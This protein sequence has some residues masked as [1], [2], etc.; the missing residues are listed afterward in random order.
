[1]YFFHGSAGDAV[2][3]LSDSIHL[4]TDISHQGDAIETAHRT[5]NVH[6]DQGVHGADCHQVGGTD[7]HV[8]I[9]RVFQCH[10]SRC[11]LTEISLSHHHGQIQVFHQAPHAF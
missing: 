11:Q 3:I 6:I 9:F 5:E 7:Y 10:V 4:L 2:E 8:L 1:M